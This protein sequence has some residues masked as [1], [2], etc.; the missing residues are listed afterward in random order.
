MNIST[1][2]LQGFLLVARLASFTRAAEQLHITQAG[3]SALIRDLEAQLGCRLFDRTT[4]S[5]SLTREGQSLVGFAERAV[6]ELEAA[7]ASLRASALQA[8]KLL[9]IAATPITAGNL[10]PEAYRVF[11]RTHPSVEVRVRDVPQ[12]AVHGLV[13]RGEVDTGFGIFI[14]PSTGT[15]LRALLE[16]QLICIAPR[17]SLGLRAPTTRQASRRG[18]PTLAWSQLPSLPLLSLPASTPPQQVV[19]A[20]LKETGQPPATGPICNS[21]Q[22]IIAMVRAG[23][24]Q[25]ILPS[26]VMPSCPPQWFDVARMVE[27]AVPLQF[28][29]ISKKGHALPIATQPFVDTLVDVVRKLCRV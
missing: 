15:E 22:T 9:T 27:P 4:R 6:H 2:Q 28:Y 20:Y 5:V 10:L 25:A 13:E 7:A 19:D 21:M 1:R 18:L 24:G 12:P 8:R 14:K 17:G 29:Q 26:M 3:L 23:H 16:F 11:T